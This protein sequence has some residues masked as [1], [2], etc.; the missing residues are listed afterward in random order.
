LFGSSAAKG[1]WSQ[2]FWGLL[3][4]IG[5]VAGRWIYRKSRKGQEP[6]PD[7]EV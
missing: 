6:L 2:F 1:K 5:V 4:F 3:L 7:E